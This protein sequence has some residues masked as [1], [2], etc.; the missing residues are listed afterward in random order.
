MKIKWN[1]YAVLLLVLAAMVL[2]PTAGRA[3]DGEPYQPLARWFGVEDGDAEGMIQQLDLPVVSH[4]GVEVTLRETLVEDQRVYLSL[5]IAW[6][7]NDEI[8]SVQVGMVEDGLTLGGESY[9][10][11]Q[12]WNLM[13]EWDPF[14][15]E[16]NHSGMRQLV[17]MSRVPKDA[18]PNGEIPMR[19]EIQKLYVE[20]D[21]APDQREIEG[22]WI[23]DFVADASTMIEQTRIVP[24]NSLIRTGRQRYQALELVYSPIR[25]RVHLVWDL[26]DEVP[27]INRFGRAIHKNLD[28][29]NLLG[30]ILKDGAGHQIEL[31]AADY[32][33]PKEISDEPLT[34]IEFDYCSGAL[35]DNLA[36]FQDA[37][38]LTLTPYAVTLFG[39]E[40][41]ADGIERYHALEP[42]PIRVEAA[43]AD[44]ESFMADFEPEYTFW[45]LFDT[46]NPYVKPVRITQKTENG[47][48][49]M[50]DK[51]LVTENSIQISVLAGTDR[52]GKDSKPLTG[53][54]IK[55][56][57]V[58]VGPIQ[59]YPPDYIEPI[60]GGGGGGGE[61][62]INAVNDEPLV[63]RN[64]IGGA[65]MFPDG[66]VSAKDPI[67]V[68]A[69]IRGIDVCWDESGMNPSNAWSCFTEEDPLIFEFE[70]DGA[71]LAALTK[72]I[73]LDETITIE[74]QELTLKRVRFN[75]LNIILFMDGY[76]IGAGH[77]A[78]DYLTVFAEADDGTTL[79]MNPWSLPFS[80][81]ERMIVDEAIN[82][83]L[84]KTES[85]KIHFCTGTWT[86]SPPAGFDPND[87]KFYKCDPAW[88]T[89]VNLE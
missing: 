68:K 34:A 21:S 50:L 20:S 31:A 79:L 60:Y 45:N 53:F 73:E 44:V 17:L 10:L 14:S 49:V 23:F 5:L 83:S 58:E 8:N 48:V 85:L 88:S 69:V 37:D 81:F 56:A 54:E 76:R 46:A 82:E 52:F 35:N 47:I 65:L 22:P 3:E 7:Q 62:Y 38:N 9:D 84:A 33:Y 1:V 43:A 2:V 78:F 63:I 61:P 67:Q 57:F 25:A 55:D 40:R 66:Y 41:E 15:D 59:P 30:F 13:M 42:I 28:D 64:L 24:L 27:L 26:T 29:R 16:A 36:W 11:V 6:D 19:L 72:E 51:V 39:P 89:T 75:P 77:S 86:K 32:D 74:G 4:G 80:G 18:L 70:T 12:D 87:M 71:E